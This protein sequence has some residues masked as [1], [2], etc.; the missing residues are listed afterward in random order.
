M[1]FVASLEIPSVS[2]LILRP[3]MPPDLARSS[4]V[5]GVSPFLLDFL[6]V[7]ETMEEGRVGTLSLTG[8]TGTK[9]GMATPS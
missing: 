5:M 2:N 3:S 4:G 6:E 8:V 1:R 9:V 7:E